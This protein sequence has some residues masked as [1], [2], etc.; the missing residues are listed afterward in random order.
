M[1]ENICQEPSVWMSTQLWPQ[2]VV[3]I[4]L[5]NIF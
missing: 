5:M 1:D 3:W 4:G 2:E